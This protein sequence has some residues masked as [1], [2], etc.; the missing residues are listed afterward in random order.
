MKSCLGFPTKNQKNTHGTFFF[1]F[2]LTARLKNQWV[3]FKGPPLK[4]LNMPG[5]GKLDHSPG[6]V[7]LFGPTPNRIP[8]CHPGGDQVTIDPSHNPLFT[9]LFLIPLNPDWLM[10]GSL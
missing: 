4:K 2:R 8:K 10:T 3:I 9:H 6:M 5:S 7:P 1:F